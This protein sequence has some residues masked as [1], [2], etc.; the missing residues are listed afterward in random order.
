MDLTTVMSAI[1]GVG[2]LTLLQQAVGLYR[3]ERRKGSAEARAQAAAPAEQ[4][5]LILGV[6]SQATGIQRQTILA[7]QEQLDKTL[8]E[9]ESL[10]QDQETRERLITRLYTRIGQ[11]EDRAGQNGP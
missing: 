1:G 6:A 10:R 7:L 8:R 9:N 2:T 5:S 11:L 3:E 4:E